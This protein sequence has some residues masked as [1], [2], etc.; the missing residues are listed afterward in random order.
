MIEPEGGADEIRVSFSDA[1]GVW[2]SLSLCG[3]RLGN[4]L[5]IISF[6]S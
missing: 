2:G 5:F 4:E 6:Q 3:Q 1:F